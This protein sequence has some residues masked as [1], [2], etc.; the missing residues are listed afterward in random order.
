MDLD[1]FPAPGMQAKAGLLWAQNTAENL[2][3]DTVGAHGYAVGVRG[4]TRATVMR[5][6]PTCSIPK[7]APFNG[8]PE[9]VPGERKLQSPKDSCGY[10]D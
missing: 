8:H 3:P 1:D 5:R 7:A 9:T 2:S 6:V 4:Q 10:E